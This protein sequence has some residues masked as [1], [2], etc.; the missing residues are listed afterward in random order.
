LPQDLSIGYIDF[1]AD[2]R[3]LVTGNTG[4]ALWNAETGERI[5]RFSEKT[6]VEGLTVSPDGRWMGVKALD[7]LNGWHIDGWHIEVWDTEKGE[8][9]R[10]FSGAN[11]PMAFTADSAYVMFAREPQGQLGVLDPR[12]GRQVAV[13]PYKLNGA[14]WSLAVSPDGSWLATCTSFREFTVWRLVP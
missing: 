12:S 11:G 5:R 9:F 8:L 10:A 7:P 13:W 4:I 14:V 1:L 6:G 2:G 3:R